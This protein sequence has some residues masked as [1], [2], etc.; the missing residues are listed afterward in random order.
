MKRLVITFALLFLITQSASNAL[1]H[2]IKT[3]SEFLIQKMLIQIKL[4][5]MNETIRVIENLSG[6]TI[7]GWVEYRYVEYMYNASQHFNIPTRIAFRLIYK[8]SAFIDTITSPKG[9]YG[10][11]QL[12]P[13]TF[14]F[15]KMKIGMPHLSMNNR[16]GNIY[17]GYYYLSYLFN[18]W[19][20]VGYD[21]KTSWTMALASYNAGIGNVIKYGGVPPFKETV[22][23]IKFI[24]GNDP[25]YSYGK[26]IDKK[27]N[28]YLALNKK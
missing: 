24:N 11:T 9:A 22:N 20:D 15:M 18:Y 16:Y 12:M 1:P 19:F 14:H 26:K 5:R 17:I 13:E 8:E 23:Y 4:D 2:Y 25:N 3:R 21:I 7:P 28:I 27:Y 6:I 10:F